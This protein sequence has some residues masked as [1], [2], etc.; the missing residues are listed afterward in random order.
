MA[1]ANTGLSGPQATHAP[2]QQ[3]LSLWTFVHTRVAR[4]TTAD[5]LAVVSALGADPTEDIKA[6]AKRLRVALTERG[7]ALKHTH[8]LDAAA[9]LQGHKGWHAAPGVEASPSLQLICTLANVDRP[10]ASWEDVVNFFS[11]IYEGNLAAGGLRT[12]VLSFTQTSMRLDS[13]NS[14]VKDRHDRTVPLLEVTWAPGPVSAIGAAIAAAETLRRRYE[15]TG[16]ALVDGIAAPQFALKT[17]EAGSHDPAFSELVAVDAGDGPSGGE[18]LARGTEVKCWYELGRINSDAA[19][20][21]RMTGNSWVFESR[22]VRWELSTVRVGGSAPE[23]VNRPLTLEESTRLFRRYELARRANMFFHADY[24]IRR[25]EFSSSESGLYDVD[26]DQVRDE[27]KRVGR[28]PNLAEKFNGG[29]KTKPLNAD[30]FFNLVKVLEAPHPSALLKP[31]TRK[32]LRRL[33]STSQLRALLCRVDD[34]L[35]EVPRRMTDATHQL[36]DRAVDQLLLALPSEVRSASGVVLGGLPRVDHHLTYANH[37][38]EF[39]HTLAL[40]GL[41]VHYG[42]VPQVKHMRKE[43]RERFAEAPYTV[44]YA[45]FLDIDFGANQ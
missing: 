11:D 4:F 43:D 42:V 16:R 29:S 45:L 24:D 3:A 35:Y 37:G 22:P 9:R 1:A 28:W 12:H 26:W 38:N 20:P 27:L 17:F 19:G 10:A 15:E 31:P 25:Y 7:V 32:G 5:A 34:V 23:V 39:L 14:R 2:E 33:D 18:E 30:Q 44:G 36:V 6:L 40:H 8:A 13:P 41:E 21:P